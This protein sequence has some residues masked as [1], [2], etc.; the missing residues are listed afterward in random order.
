VARKV[1]LARGRGLARDHH[2]R[3]MMMPREA[4]LL[5]APRDL[6][7]LFHPFSFLFPL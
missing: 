1:D 5:F 3:R 6:S 2:A 4:P 7:A